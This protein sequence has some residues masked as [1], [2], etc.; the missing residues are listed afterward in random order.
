VN[1]PET[2]LTG[3]DQIISGTTASW[4]A[5]S[6]FPPGTAWHINICGTDFS[7]GQHSFQVENLEMRL[8]DDAITIVSGTDKPISLFT[9]FTALS[10]ADQVLLDYSGIDGQ[11]IYTYAPEFRVRIQAETYAGNYTSTITTTFIV[12]P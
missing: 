11:G 12:G 10:Q 1:F 7:D 6:A 2:A 3:A 8:L 4:E 5:S 9:S